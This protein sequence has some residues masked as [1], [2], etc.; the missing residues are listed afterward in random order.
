[1]EGD[2]RDGQHD[3]SRRD[4]AGTT[5][6]GLEGHL[7]HAASVDA[8]RRQDPTRADALAQSFM[9]RGALCLGARAD[10]VGRSHYGD[11]SFQLDFDFLDHVLRASASD[12]GQEEIGLYPRSVAAE[13]D[14][15]DVR[16]WH[17]VGHRH[18]R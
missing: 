12:G 2:C 10:H 14:R 13:K 5:A 8:D 18:P 4:M 7:C 17:L 3:I 1:M 9:A 6:I 11:R 15:L 16:L